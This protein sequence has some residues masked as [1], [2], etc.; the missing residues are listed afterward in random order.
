M[1]TVAIAIPETHADV[2]RARLLRED[3]QQ[4][5]VSMQYSCERCG[6]LF[7]LFFMNGADETNDE[8]AETLRQRI[9]AGCEDGCHPFEGYPLG[10]P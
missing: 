2:I 6:T 8:Y 10:R 7:V 3:P 9:V 1:P 4:I 5:F